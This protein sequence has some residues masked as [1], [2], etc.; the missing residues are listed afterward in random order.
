[1]HCVRGLVLVLDLALS[2][3]WT[4]LW[5]WRV[6]HLLQLSL[7][8]Q[9]GVVLLRVCLTACGVHVCVLLLRNLLRL[10]LLL[11]LGS[12]LLGLLHV[13]LGPLLSIARLSIAVG[14][15][16]VVLVG[17]L[18]VIVRGSVIVSTL[19]LWSADSRGG[20]HRVLTH[21]TGRL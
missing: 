14:N 21:L 12:V 8:H 10:L 20:V 15:V 5:L 7:A 11:L 19:L 9:L 6:A 4:L 1:M 18:V 17:C 13:V 16:S 2:L 3:R